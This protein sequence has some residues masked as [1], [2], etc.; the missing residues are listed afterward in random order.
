LSRELQVICFFRDSTNVRMAAVNPENPKVPTLLKKLKEKYFFLSA[1]LYLISP[2]SF[3][4]SI[5]VYGTLPKYTAVRPGVKITEEDLLRFKQEI[6]N[7]QNIHEFLSR[8]NISDVMTIIIAA[9][10]KIESTDIHIEAGQDSIIIRY[11]VDGILQEVAQ[12]SSERWREV[13]SRLKVISKVKIN[14]S[15]KPQDGRFTIFLEGSEI[16]VRVSFLPTSNGESVVMRLLMADVG[17]LDIEKLGMQPQAE[18]LLLSEISKPNGLILTT[19]PTGSGKTTTLYAVVNKL[20][21]PGIKIIALEDPIEYR[22]KGI[23]QSQVDE[24]K[25]YTF[26]KG[27]RSILRQDPDI[28]LVGEIRDLE[29]AEITIQAS[30]TG[31]LVLST[32]HTNDSSGVIPRLIDLGVKPF[33]LTPAINAILGQ[34]LVRKLCPACKQ[35]HVLTETETEQIKKILAVIS[36]KAGVNIPVNLSTIYK[37]GENST[38]SFCHGL[39]YKG[40]IGIY[41]IFSMNDE[42]K[43]LTA[44]GA[45]AF[46]LLEQAIEDGMI[47]MLQDGVLKALAGLTSLEEVYTAIGKM[48]YV[49]TLFDIITAQTIGR[50]LKITPEHL[51]VGAKMAANLNQAE[52]VITGYKTAEIINVVIAAGVLS[53]AGDIHIDPEEKIVRIR[54]RVDGILHDIASLP[55]EYYVPLIS[56]IKNLIGAAANLKQSTYEGRFSIYTPETRMDCRV[57]IITG[58]YGE[59]AVL[60]IL[61]KQASAL[62]VEELGI[63]GKT[64]EIILDAIT[65]TRGI[66]VN[67]GP[68]GSG[69]TTTLYSLL[70]RLNKPDIKIITIEDPIE[71]HLQGIMQ[72]QIDDKSGYTFTSALKSLL[73]QNPNVIMIGEVRDEATA[74]TAIE[75]A[76][77]G[78]LV[79]STV[80]ANS[81]AGGVARFAELGVERSFLAG[82]IECSIGQRLVRKIC[83]HCKEVYQPTKEESVT[84]TRYLS[85][86]KPTADL[87]IPTE[88]VFYKGKGCELCSHLGYKGRLGLYEAISVNSE[89]KK[90]LMDEKMTDLDIELAA[91]EQGFVPLI[92]DGIIKALNGETTLEEV[93]RVAK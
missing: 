78:H 66:I 15:D 33:L 49:D 62:A 56:E 39:S 25:G 68:T 64:L 40:R 6:S 32:L 26:A 46:K 83:P 69:K 16:D 53:E 81:A 59:T 93:L 60:R 37:A 28:V 44:S 14:I 73:R 30:L 57:S 10:L 71:Y 48:D 91:M 21:Q 34:R 1:E 5:V 50:G 12:L 22:L 79:L 38:C 92:A 9:A 17:T 13:V 8:A 54:F 23:S 86:L 85:A 27:L 4:K 67:T 19:G 61:S 72:T 18:A 35:E 42:M 63:R 29:T 89:I 11:R 20:N 74:K 84:V 36:P 31:H 90:I 52:E 75:A 41:E 51:A 47:T 3:E 65:K 82:S 58:G 24:A 45:P 77:S 80:H 55:Q 88:L 76:L 2:H 87:Q 43:Q 7:L 70:N